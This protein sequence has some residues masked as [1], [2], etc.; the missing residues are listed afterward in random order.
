[1]CS[2]RDFAPMEIRFGRAMLQAAVMHG[3]KI[4]NVVSQMR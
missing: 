4:F 1:M 3:M 2:Y